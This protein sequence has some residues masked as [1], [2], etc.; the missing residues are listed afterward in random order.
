MKK[1]RF[2]RSRVFCALVA[3]LLAFPPAMMD[4]QAASKK[5]SRR[6]RR[7]KPKAITSVQAF[8]SV[9]QRAIGRECKRS[10]RLGV[11]IRSAS[12]RETLFSFNGDVK[13]IPASNVKLFTTAAALAYL[14]PD[15]T[16][17]TDVY[18]HGDIRGG[19]L[20]G[21]LYI[22]GYGDPSFVQERVRELAYQVR[23]RGIREIS[24]DLVADDT[25]FEKSS[26]RIGR[27]R[28]RRR[29]NSVKAYLA[30]N[31]ALSVNFSVITVQAVPGPR[32]GAPARVQL[33]PPSDTIGLKNTLKTVSKRRWPFVRVTRTNKNGKDW[34]HV[35][36]KMPIRTKNWRHNVTVS[37]PVRF[38]A[39]AFAAFLRRE[40]VSLRGK[41]RRGVT[42]V[43]AKLAVRQN[44]RSLGIIIRGLNKHSN[45]MIAEQILKTIGAE[46]VGLPGSTEKG[47]LAVQKFLVHAGVP[48][49]SF[50]LADGSGLSRQNRITPRAMVTLL[51]GVHDD[52]RIWPEY[53]ASLAV[54]GVDGT[55]KKRLRGSSAARRIRAKTGLLAGVRALSGYATSK[56]GE[57]LVFSILSN[58]HRCRAKNLMNRI[59]IAMTKFDRPLPAGLGKS[60]G[61]ARR[62]LSRPMPR[63]ARRDRWRRSGRARNGDKRAPGGSPR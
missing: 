6:A 34:F 25:F 49:G 38:A 58:A 27:R 32:P 53:I 19:K 41:I 21:D 47:L 18:T 22:K 61:P 9:V 20:N 59:S 4:V 55:I 51:E 1:A 31:S 12:A 62:M 43:E 48:P 44:S 2:S 39:G 60:L 36:G 14:G 5:R 26:R 16:F 7:A 35:S 15:Y 11:F 52:F 56:N 28:K 23:L 50:N 57:T 17:P 37:D 40:G 13:R 46:M 63:P 42:P 45:N 29:R 10:A 24:G 54:V 30:P 8:R 3:L 33:I